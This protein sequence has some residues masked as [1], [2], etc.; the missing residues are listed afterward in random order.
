[1]LAL[2]SVA[3]IPLMQI[4][5]GAVLDFGARAGFGAGA[6]YRMAFGCLGAMIFA[7]GLVYATARNADEES[8]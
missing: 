5:F 1:L 3:A 6:Q 4:G 8:V 2:V 7:C